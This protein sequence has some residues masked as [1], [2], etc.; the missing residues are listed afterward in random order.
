MKYFYP[1]LFMFF[2]LGAC[3]SPEQKKFEILSEFVQENYQMDIRDTAYSIL[4]YPANQC[5]T[6]I[7]YEVFDSILA[8][9]KY[10]IITNAPTKYLERYKPFVYY[11]AK[12]ALMSFEPNEYTNTIWNFADNKV[13]SVVKNLPISKIGQPSLLDN[14]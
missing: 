12:S 5:L 14:P 13:S 1:L 9:K 2:G 6:C 8:E 11:D 4:F 3:K 10:L 7:D